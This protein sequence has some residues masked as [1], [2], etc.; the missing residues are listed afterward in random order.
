[1]NKSEIKLFFLGILSD[2]FYISLITYVF[3]A[4]LEILHPRFVTAY[5]NLN[6]LLMIVLIT[7]IITIMKEED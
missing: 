7:G 4:A 1:M 3:F 2:I 6:A 5:F